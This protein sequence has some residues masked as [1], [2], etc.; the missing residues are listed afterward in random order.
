MEPF[1]DVAPESGDDEIE[2]ARPLRD[3]IDGICAWQYLQSDDAHANCQKLLPRPG[4]TKDTKERPILF[5]QSL[6]SGS[7]RPLNTDFSDFLKTVVAGFIVQGHPFVLRIVKWSPL[8]C[9]GKATFLVLTKFYPEGSLHDMLER[10][11][12]LPPV[13]VLYCIARALIHLQVMKV[14]H[15]HVC[16]QAVFVSAPNEKRPFFKAKL[17]LTRPATTPPADDFDG[18]RGLCDRLG[19][20]LPPHIAQLSAAAEFL[21]CNHMSDVWRLKELADNFQR[22][23]SSRAGKILSPSVLFALNSAGRGKWAQLRD[24]QKEAEKAPT[25][26]ICAWLGLIYECGIGV[27]RDGYRAFDYYARCSSSDEVCRKRLARLTDR[28]SAPQIRGQA[29]ARRG[30]VEEAAAAF[31]ECTDPLGIARFGEFLA[32][33]AD[34]AAREQGRRLLEAAARRGCGFASFSL[35]KLCI[36]SAQPPY[37]DNI[38]DNPYS[39]LAARRTAPA[40]KADQLDAAFRHLV[41]ADKLGYPDAAF[42]IGCVCAQTGGEQDEGEQDGQP[43]ARDQSRDAEKW[44]RRAATDFHDPEAKK[45]IQRWNTI[46]GTQ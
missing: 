16:A 19:F 20:A 34:G 8:D 40:W 24:L 46:R 13:P 18:F 3:I 1:A 26:E 17:G 31:S 32:A 38:A 23:Q 28:E 21:E 35:G 12:R 29:F 45:L 7:D 41:E 14:P 42:L 25:G 11:D 43:A 22:L 10:G 9:K 4:D 33:S 30:M 2:S 39:I 5:M 6:K 37:P 44:F 15:G 36:T 27:D